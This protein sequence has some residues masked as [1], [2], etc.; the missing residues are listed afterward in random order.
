MDVLFKCIGLAFISVIL[1][2]SIDKKEFGLILVIMTCTGVGFVVFAKIQPI[3]DLI[4]EI[5]NIGNICDDVLAVLIKAAG[6][7]LISD[8]AGAVCS[9]CGN[10]SIG[11]ILYFG[12]LRKLIKS[13]IAQLPAP[14]PIDIIVASK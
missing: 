7:A 13:S 6:I 8:F 11:K 14:R 4:S 3:L 2:L 9:D 5:T 10:G 12:F 1:G